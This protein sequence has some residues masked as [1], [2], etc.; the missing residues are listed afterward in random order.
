M[1]HCITTKFNIITR[2]IRKYFFY[3]I[4]YR[5]RNLVYSL[6]LNSLIIR[7]VLY[8][9]HI[10]STV[11]EKK[12]KNLTLK[13]K[14]T[15][16]SFVLCSILSNKE[17]FS[18]FFEKKNFFFSVLIKFENMHGTNTYTHTQQTKN[19]KHRRRRKK[20]KNNHRTL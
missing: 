16:A 4:Q 19:K 13:Q 8:C 18:F 9:C 15:K 11:K 20:R 14:K 6:S 10:H 17:H 12:K 1:T 3:K 7:I 2:T 5:N